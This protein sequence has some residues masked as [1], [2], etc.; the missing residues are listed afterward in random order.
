GFRVAP[1]TGLNVCDPW[2]HSGVLVLPI[3]I[4]PAPRIRAATRSSAAG[5]WLAWRGEPKVVRIPFVA[6]RSLT[7]TGR[8]QSG[9]SGPAR[10]AASAS[11][12]SSARRRSVTMALTAGLTS[13]IR[14]RKATI[15]VRALRRP[16]RKAR[17]S[18][19][20]GTL[21]TS[22][23]RG[24]VVARASRGSR[25]AMPPGGSGA[26]A[27]GTSLLQ[28]GPDRR[29]VFLRLRRAGRQELAR[30]PELLG[31]DD[32]GRRLHV[33]RHE[34]VRSRD[35]VG[36]AREGRDQRRVLRN[37][38]EVEELVGFLHVRGVLEQHHL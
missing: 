7:A 5:T 3:R 17:A 35:P 22:I 19:Q 31:H 28:L 29:V 36:I 38:D 6:T 33:F 30:G 10:S 37:H 12:R 1:K 11:A 13:S 15:T 9:P 4:A 25:G 21:V 26:R 8:P 20:A 16:P 18:S 34:G 32:L 14:S 2:P 27:P 23:C 24:L